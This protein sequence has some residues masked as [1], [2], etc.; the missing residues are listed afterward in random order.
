LRY[1]AHSRVTDS[2]PEQRESLPPSGAGLAGS[3]P[4]VSESLRRF[5][6]D[7]VRLSTI[8]FGRPQDFL[9][10]GR[11][12][13]LR[14]MGVGVLLW[15]IVA[16]LEW[17]GLPLPPMVRLWMSLLIG[18]IILQAA[19]D[20]LVTATERSAARLSWDHYVAGTIAEILSTLPEL[21]VIAFV[22][23]VS[24]VAATV[25]ALVTIYNNALVF[26][27]YS[28]FLPK[29]QKGLFVMPTAITEAG[30]QLLAAGATL[31]SILGLGMLVLSSNGAQ[32]QHFNPVDLLVLAGVM[33][34]IFG[35][36]IHKLV[37][38]YAS[39]ESLLRQALHLDEED[40]EER[41]ELIYAD[42][43]RVSWWNIL[44]VF[45]VGV[46]GAFMG[47]ERV[48]RFAETALR[49]L[50]LNPIAAAV[51]LAG[52]AGMSEYVIV[53]RAH[54]RGR[55]GIALANAFGGMTQVMFLVLPFTLFAVGLYQGFLDPAHPELP[56]RF[57][58]SFI[59][60]FI[61]LFP[62]FFV[63][64]ELIEDD[65]TFGI[66]DTVIMASMCLLTLLILLAY[67]T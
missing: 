41:K 17:A 33:W 13:W 51:I 48:S 42:V 62:T 10:H 36:Y 44:G 45:V 57:D 16:G 60:L 53:W 38:G 46:A 8:P 7:P 61:F 56:L 32:K 18:L 20:A 40:V 54:R 25:L 21:V 26:S 1:D 6:L 24:P 50:S 67:G 59:L 9:W 27:L 52:F 34:C 2:T 55:H 28:Y 31:G 47:G 58:V 65:H 63:L 12:P 23:P 35:V 49:D 5:G 11:P 39:E 66:L 29:D 37:K 64:L 43:K 4:E 3:P 15:A 30:T 14:R 19:C 22:V